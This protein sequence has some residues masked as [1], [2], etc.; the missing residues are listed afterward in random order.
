MLSCY[1]LSTTVYFPTIIQ[2]LSSTVIDN[3]FTDA[4]TI[5]NYSIYSLIIVLSDHD[6]L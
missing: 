5:N 6:A 2:T 4:L 1:N 3:I